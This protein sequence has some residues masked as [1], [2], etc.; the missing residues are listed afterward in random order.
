MINKIC[1]F[2][3]MLLLSAGAWADEYNPVNP[4][5]PMAKFRLTVS[6]SPAEAGYASG[7]GLYQSGTSVS[8]STSARQ[9]YEFLYWMCDG[10][11]VSDIMSFRYTMPNKHVSLVAVYGYNP[12]N[13]A[14][15]VTQNKYKLYLETN[16]EGSCTFNIVSGSKQSANQSI[17]VI[18]Q[19]ISQ[20]YKFQGWYSGDT[21]LSNSTSFYYRMPYQ[22][23]TLTAHFVY[24]PDSPDDPDSNEGQTSVDVNKPGDVNGDGFVTIEDAKMVM[25]YYLASDKGTVQGFNLSVAD[26][27]GDGSVTM[28]D[29]NMIVSM[30]LAN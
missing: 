30:C 21:K 24:D 4:P 15:P 16:L 9:N 7:G 29:A 8:V 11:Q 14:D 23:I 19:N 26:V 2:V 6:V 12:V 17:R 5:D 20:G 27:N 18:A 22:D 13:P 10:V 25:N 28:T 3:T 1:I